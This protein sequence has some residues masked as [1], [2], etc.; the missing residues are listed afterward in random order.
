MLSG[1]D[2]EG[3]RALQESGALVILSGGVSSLDDVRRIAGTTLAGVIIGRAL[4]ENRVTLPGALAV[5]AGE[6]AG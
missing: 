4:Y 3:A 5:A 6:P 2:I 1:P